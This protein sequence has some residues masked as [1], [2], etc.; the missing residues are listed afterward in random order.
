MTAARQERRRSEDGSLICENTHLRIR[1]IRE[2][3][4]LGLVIETRGLD[5][6]WG[7]LAFASSGEDIHAA[8]ADGADQAGCFFTFNPLEI[9][10]AT[11]GVTLQGRLGNSVLALTA[12][13]DEISTWCRLQLTLSGIPPACRRLTQQW[14]LLPGETPPEICWPAAA[15]HG[16]ALAY[17][18][19]AFVQDGPVFAALVVD[20]GEDDPACCG[21]EVTTSDPICFEYGLW[22][23]GEANLPDTPLQLTFHLGLDARALPERGFQ[24]VVR[25]L[26]SREELALPGRSQAQPAAGALPELP[27]PDGAEE[28]HPFIW[29]G[30]LSA[31]VAAV[32]QYLAK[33][34]AGD[35]QTLEDGLCWLDRL[36]LQQRTSG[37]PGATTLG[38]FGPETDWHT[39]APWMPI[40][41]MQAARLTG[42]PE[43]GARAQAAL[44]ALPPDVQSVVLGHLHPAFGDLYV[45]ADFAELVSLSGPEV[46][47]AQFTPGGLELT[48]MPEATRLRLVLDSSDDAYTLTINGKH[49]DAFDTASLRAGIDLDLTA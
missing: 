11:R 33:A 5:M 10:G 44:N 2:G 26:G 45:Q 1:V 41:L 49:L 43:Y 22:D 20:L 3:R 36:C 31:L 24:Q 29:E 9:G 6:C 32:R 35:C 15:T 34:A 37:T 25:L 8:G 18:P 42:S 47:G 13:L 14:R 16:E 30:T 17:S 38:A 40:L 27:A 7:T 46:T 48:V 4:S 12:T 21:L 23:D 39:A 19:A 28:W